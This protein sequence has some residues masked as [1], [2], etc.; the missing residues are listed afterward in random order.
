VNI[1]FVKDPDIHG[2]KTMQTVLELEQ[3]AA[4]FR[5]AHSNVAGR[6]IEVRREGGMEGGTEGGRR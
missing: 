1:S 5:S 3:A 6:Y 4:Q 2:S